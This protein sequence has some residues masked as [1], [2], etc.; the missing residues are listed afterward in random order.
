[1][2]SYELHPAVSASNPS[3]ASLMAAA[4]AAPLFGSRLNSLPIQRGWPSCQPAVSKMP[5]V[6]RMSPVQAKSLGHSSR[7]GMARSAAMPG[8]IDSG[9]QVS[10]PTAK[11]G[12]TP[13]VNHAPS[14]SPPLTGAT[15]HRQRYTSPSL[16]VTLIA[17][18]AIESLCSNTLIS[19]F[20]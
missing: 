6:V 16:A 9:T 10:F 11:G 15:C 1:M 18:T 3:K 8:A 14:F 4:T 12:E 7:I 2:A 19:W 20:W 17:K 13:I 5:P